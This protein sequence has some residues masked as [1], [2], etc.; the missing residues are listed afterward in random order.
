MEDSFVGTI[1]RSAVFWLVYESKCWSKGLEPAMYTFTRCTSKN[2]IEC[3]KDN[4]TTAKCLATQSVSYK[5]A[6][7]RDW[8]QLL[9]LYCI[10]I[11]YAGV[12]IAVASHA[13][14][15]SVAACRSLCAAEHK[16]RTG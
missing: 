8:T 16:T 13:N 15:A 7:S 2:R 9:G 1:R 6:G 5:Q 12:L 10:C 4:D 11:L 3:V 14:E